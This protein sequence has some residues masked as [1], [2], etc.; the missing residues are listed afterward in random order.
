MDGLYA[1]K[2]YSHKTKLNRAI[3][4]FSHDWLIDWFSPVIDCYDQWKEHSNNQPHIA[5]QHPH[6]T[7]FMRTPAHTQVPYITIEYTIIS[8]VWRF[9]K[10]INC[11]ITNWFKKYLINKLMCVRSHHLP[12]YLVIPAAAFGSI[13]QHTACCWRFSSLFV[14]HQRHTGVVFHETR[15]ARCDA[16]RSSLFANL[17][18]G[19]NHYL[20]YSLI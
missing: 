17:F 19:K 2:P 15:N 9:T 8:S 11:F 16:D 10:I 7:Q 3:D 13:P 14:F 5:S 18:G 1:H 4:Y 12:A 6:W 20:V